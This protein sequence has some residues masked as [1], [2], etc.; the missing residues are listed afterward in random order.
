MTTR[1]EFIC[2]GAAAMAV[3][4]RADGADD[5]VYP[6][7]RPGEL[8][9]HFIH[10]G[11]GEQTFFI[12]PDGTTML[13]DCGDTHHAKYM[14]DVPPLPSAERCG[15]EWVSRYLRRLTPRREIDYL[16]VSHWHGDHI[17]DPSLGCWKNAK[18]EQICGI[19]AVADDFRFRRYFDHQFP[20]PGRYAHD[21][22]PEAYARFQTWLAKARAA[23]LDAQPFRVG[24]LDQIRLQRDAARYPQ[25][26]IRNLCA[27]AVVWDGKDGS[28]DCG[29]EHVKSGRKTI[30]ENR[31]S[32]AIRIDYG[33]FSYYTGGDNELELHRADGTPFSWERRVGETCGPVDVAKTNHHAGTHAMSPEFCAAVRPRV[34]LSSV[35]QANMVDHHSLKPM[36]SRE[37]YPGER[38]VCFGHVADKV[39]TVAAAYGDDIAPA[40][41][42]VVKVA[43]GG[44]VYEVFTLDAR[45]ESMRILARRQFASCGRRG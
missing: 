25:F 39:K 36:C 16:M 5:A 4:R 45:D 31:L 8:D 2:T 30:H 42:A 15:G 44:D 27:N 12:F 22:D 17:G 1:R 19:T 37:L 21:P 41:H 9:I 11:V 13:L 26:H 28:V 40:G 7:W 24:A 23:G 3:L 35:W 38:Y 29:A 43:P 33:R 6:G 34:W 18:G 10:T 20:D 32:A 14:R